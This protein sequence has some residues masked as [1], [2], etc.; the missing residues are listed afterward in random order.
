M[1]MNSLIFII[2]S[3]IYLVL[4]L[5]R[6][7]STWKKNL[8]GSIFIITFIIGTIMPANLVKNYYMGKYN[9]DRE[10]SY[11]TISFLRLGMEESRRGNGWYR[12]DIGEYALKNPENAKKEYPE[13]IKERLKFFG[14]N[15]GY[16]FRFYTM[17]IASMW[18]E[19]T[20]ASV[21]ENLNMDDIELSNKISNLTGVIAVY[22]KALLVLTATISLMV[23]IKTRKNLS[24]EVLFLITIFIGGFMFHILWE[25][26][27]R[28]IIPYVV[29]LIP[30]ASIKLDLFKKKKLLE[31]NK[32]TIKE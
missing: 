5:I 22:Q 24:L 23:L 21:R 29:I 31:E 27:S 3:V 30:V 9:L 25:A 13:L 20:Y 2:A 26:K 8:I 19:N 32:E 14:E 28:Y 7:K 10:K 18:T 4:C 11:P 15:L 6:D 16:T 12:E 17:K 1:R